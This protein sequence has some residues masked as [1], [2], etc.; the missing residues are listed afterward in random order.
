MD[1]SFSW[2]F[3][4]QLPINQP[5][6]EVNHQLCV[7]ELLE[8]HDWLICQCQQ[9]WFKMLTSDCSQG[10]GLWA[11]H[12]A[13]HLE[14]R[15]PRRGAPVM[16]EHGFAHAWPCD[17]HSDLVT[18]CFMILHAHGSGKTY[19]RQIQRHLVVLGSAALLVWT[20]RFW[21]HVPHTDGWFPKPSE[22][23]RCFPRPINVTMNLK[24]EASKA[25]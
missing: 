10:S 24:W 19:S 12:G 6:F 3:P 2:N 18:W 23:P 20:F 25:C 7:A 4:I 17:F 11:N 16:W 15:V 8:V 14:I 1:G 9:V 21:V 13:H 5:Y 22:Q